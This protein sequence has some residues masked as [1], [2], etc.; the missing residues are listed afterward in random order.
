VYFRGVK[1]VQA[2]G[3]FPEIQNISGRLNGLGEVT[4]IMKSYGWSRQSL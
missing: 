4:A 2:S 3:Y 1:R